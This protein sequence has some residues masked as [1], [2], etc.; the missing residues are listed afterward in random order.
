MGARN[1]L[2]EINRL[3][4]PVFRCAG[5]AARL[6]LTCFVVTVAYNLENTLK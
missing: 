3:C 5:V 2:A 4:M 6:R 1:G